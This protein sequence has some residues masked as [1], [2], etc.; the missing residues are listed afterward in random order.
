MRP[1]SPYERLAHREIYR[2]PWVAVEVHDVI[3]PSGAPGEH[4]SI[5]TGRASGV[6]VI[7]GASFIFARQGRFAADAEMVEIVKGGAE[8]G[9]SALA[10]AQRELREELGLRASVWTALGVAY[11]VPS[12]I[13]HPVALFLARNV[14]AVPAAQELVERIDAVRLSVDDAY[15]AA[16]DGRIDDAVTLAAL[17]RYLLISE[18]RN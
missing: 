15:R 12:I 6:L 5:A 16:R 4:V 9:E 7:E 3:H 17:L 18:T 2:N 11:E 8:E 13:E 1:P 10:C 14:R